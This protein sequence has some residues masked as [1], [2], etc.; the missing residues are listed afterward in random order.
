MGQPSNQELKCIML[1]VQ[2]MLSEQQS[3]IGSLQKKLDDILPALNS[4]QENTERLS[5]GVES[6]S[7]NID[8]LFRRER[9][10]NLVFF[11]VPE[12]EDA[13]DMLSFIISTIKKYGDVELSPS[14]ISYG[15]WIGKKDKAK[16]L[17]ITFTSRFTKERVLKVAPTFRARGISVS[18]DRSKEERSARAGMRDVLV[19]LRKHDTSAHIRGSSI[20]YLN[21]RLDFESALQLSRQLPASPLPPEQKQDSMGRNK[22]GLSLSPGSANENASKK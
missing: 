16:P 20:F 19:N 3:S 2:K 9:Y 7:R 8:Y 4:L 17:L 21:K 15:Y 12:P 13:V 22:R 18:L 14:D 5:L 10:N 6:N 1:G 11:N